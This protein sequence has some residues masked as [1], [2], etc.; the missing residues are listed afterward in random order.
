[1]SETVKIV[2]RE[3]GGDIRSEQYQYLYVNRT[4]AAFTQWDIQIHLARMT[5]IEPGVPGIEQVGL[6][7]MAP[8]HAKAVLT[9]LQAAVDQY[10]SKFG[11]IAMPPGAT[12]TEVAKPVKK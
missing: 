11:S 8:A 9:I 10:E 7:V 3:S 5:E 12:E 4:S 6:V 2:G 1:M